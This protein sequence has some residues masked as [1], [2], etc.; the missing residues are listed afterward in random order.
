[1]IHGKWQVITALFLP[2][3][4]CGP[5]LGRN[6]WASLE[7]IL[8]MGDSHQGNSEHGDP[9]YRHESGKHREIELVPA[10]LLIR[11]KNKLVRGLGHWN[12][13]GGDLPRMQLT[14]FLQIHEWLDYQNDLEWVD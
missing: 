2:L 12:S 3:A 9:I 8:I 7:R 14:W 4:V 6:R 5:P 13:Y 11:R 1:M 10:T